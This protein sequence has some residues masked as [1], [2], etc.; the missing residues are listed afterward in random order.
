[1]ASGNSNQ[2]KGI[3]ESFEGVEV[4]GS[5]HRAFVAGGGVTRA[6]MT[7]GLP[8]R[9]GYQDEAVASI[10][11]GLTAGARGTAVL[12]CGTGKTLVAAHAT[13]Q[14][15]AAGLVVVAC[16]SLALVAQTLGVWRRAG[17]PDA[18]MAVCSDAT[19]ADADAYAW[20]MDCP[21]TTNADQIAGW[22][23]GTRGANLR[24]VLVTH[25]SALVLGRGVK[26]ADQVVDLLVVD[27]AH[28]TA[29]S[30]TKQAAALHHDATLPARRRVYMTATPRVMTAGR[31]G[32]M[33]TGLSMDDPDI[34]GPRLFTYPF[35]AAI[36]DGWL[37]DYRVVV[38]GVTRREVHDLLRGI[39]EDAVLEPGGASL[40]TMVAQAALIKAAAEY[41]LRRILVFT[42][43]VKESQEFAATLGELLDHLPVQERPKGLL[44]AVHVDGTHDV[45]QRQAALA[46]LIDPPEDGWTV[47]SNPGCLS[48]GVD[49]PAVD[50]VVFARRRE[51]E[52]DIV[53]AVGRAL[54]RNPRGS[55][56]ATI[57]VPVLVEDPGDASGMDEKWATVCQVVRALR[58]HDADLGIHLD[59]QRARRGAQTDPDHAHKGPDRAHGD[60]GADAPTLPPQVLLRLPDG[61][62][63]PEVLRHIA[64][65]VLNETTDPWW[66][67]FGQVRAYHATH[68]RLPGIDHPRLANWQFLQRRQYAKHNLDAQQIAALES[69]GFVWS[70]RNES[71]ER[72]LVAAREFYRQHG[73]LNVHEDLVVNGV[74]LYPYLAHQRRRDKEGKLPAE[75]KAELTR[76]GLRFDTKPQ[77]TWPDA[78]HLAVTY[79]QEHRH[80]RVPRG[81]TVGNFDL[82]AW[83]CLQRQLRRAGKL[84]PEQVAKLDALGMIWDIDRAKW[85]HNF[86]AAEA[87]AKREGH[88]KPRPGHNEGDV[89]LYRWLGHQLKLYREGTLSTERAHRLISIGMPLRSRPTSRRPAART[90]ASPASTDHA[91]AAFTL[92]GAG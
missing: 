15:V 80:L 83:V 16:P 84:K 52:T 70:P 3:D 39:D 2:E 75:L 26:A 60:P 4:C 9:R 53:Q 65:R 48:E 91:D 6:R 29:G 64:V 32:G 51:S 24:L 92:A 76:M 7:R 62:G 43:L 33:V 69:I 8:P 57:L 77:V 86:A 12:A 72:G 74:A 5:H 54:R 90:T 71:R 59:E 85:D 34:Y 55:G 19:V 61:Y 78:Y 41:R 23:R 30:H 28:R 67:V 73:H 10:V 82:Y 88:L 46:Q 21:V 11:N 25:K 45:A 17:I 49:V 36:T 50:A 42:N 44:T 35:A 18:V 1:M 56:I 81:T 40:P 66:E 13:V 14:M 58:A 89:Q 22:L 20:Q 87:F 31:R 63:L 79:H 27:E 38:L 47:V 37:D 68:G